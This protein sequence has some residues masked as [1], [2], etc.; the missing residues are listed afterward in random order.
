MPTPT[1]Q[2]RYPTAAAIERLTEMF[3]LPPGGQDWEIEVA[4]AARLGEFLDGYERQPLGD[5]ERFTL[6]ELIVASYDELL[7]GG[8]QDRP[9]D[10][11]RVRLHLLQRFDLHGYTV[12]YWSL[13]DED[14][15]ENGFAVTGR[16]REV[17]AGFFG[18]RERWPRRPF[19]VRRYIDG[20][21]PRVPGAALDVLDISD[22]RDESFTLS[23]SRYGRR[24]PGER[25]FPTVAQAEEFAARAFGVARSRWA[26]V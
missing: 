4:D 23:W 18:P 17:I 25:V 11:A 1:I 8:G 19:V 22:N 21:D 16:M 3:R 13:P 24:R 7:E 15:P 14:D 6:M 12:Q 9:E 26:D 10:W 20:P 5:D 2:P